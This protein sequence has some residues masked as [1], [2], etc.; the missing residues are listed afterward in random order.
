ME[1]IWLFP[2]LWAMWGNPEYTEGYSFAEINFA[3][4][5]EYVKHIDAKYIPRSIARFSDL[6]LDNMADVSEGN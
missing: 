1:G 6:K 2:G 5:E 4:R 3:L